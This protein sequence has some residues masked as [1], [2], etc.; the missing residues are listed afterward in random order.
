MPDAKQPISL[1]EIAVSNMIAI[2]A[3]VRVM[4]NKGLVAQNE[5][6]EEIKHVKL[7]Q[8]ANRN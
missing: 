5:I 4:V 8:Q 2:E 3:I 6:L 1:E 7:E